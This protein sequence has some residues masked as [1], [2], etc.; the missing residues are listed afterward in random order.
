MYE[1][2]QRGC[3]NDDVS[4]LGVY[5][6]RMAFPAGRGAMNFPSLPTAM[7]QIKTMGSDTVGFMIPPRTTRPTAM[8]VDME[9]LFLPI[10]SKHPQEAA[11][12]LVYLH[13]PER[14]KALADELGY[15]YVPDDRFDLNWIEDPAIRRGLEMG[16]EG[17]EI[18]VRMV[19][20][21]IPYSIFSDGFFPALQLM[22]SEN[23][24]PDKAAA[25]VQEAA[26]NWRQLN[27]EQVEQYTLWYEET[28]AKME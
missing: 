8:A 14:M 13:S 10:F 6:G 23:L 26:E 17:M 22:F 15:A 27:P 25:M 19:E 21:L 28:K 3:F 5:D 24:E 4:S 18:E 9:G 1:L 16:K 12:F 11:D 20:S 7:E 2:K